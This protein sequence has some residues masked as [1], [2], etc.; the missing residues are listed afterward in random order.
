M[1]SL[2]LAGMALRTRAR[3]VL[4]S[5]LERHHSCFTPS[6]HS[7][8]T[9]TGGTHQHEALATTGVVNKTGLLVSLGRP[10]PPAKGYRCVCTTGTIQHK[11]EVQSKSRRKKLFSDMS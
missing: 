3:E 7:L 5:V 4:G 11:A 9:Q 10:P 2:T 6:G 8:P 1:A